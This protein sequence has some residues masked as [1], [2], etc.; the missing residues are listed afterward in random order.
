MGYKTLENINVP[1][2]SNVV[3][4]PIHCAVLKISLADL[5]KIQEQT[6][7]TRVY[8]NSVINIRKGV[9]YYYFFSF[10]AKQNRFYIDSFIFCLHFFR[11]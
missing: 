3:L 5:K 1:H 11:F 7:A 2:Y 6:L 9:P 8:K 4:L 10:W